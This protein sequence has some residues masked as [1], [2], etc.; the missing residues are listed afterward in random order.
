MFKKESESKSNQIKSKKIYVESVS[1]WVEV[2]LLNFREVI[3]WRDVHLAYGR[4]E[5][6]LQREEEL[7]W[8]QA[9]VLLLK[10]V[11]RD[12]FLLP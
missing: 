11:P 4:R 9:L 10:V 1:Q 6:Q 12:F 2:R 3:R 7:L 5:M 8:K